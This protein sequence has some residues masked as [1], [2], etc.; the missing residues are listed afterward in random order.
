MLGIGR[1]ATEQDVKK[2]YYQLAKKWHPDTNKVRRRHRRRLPDC[3][4]TATA[5]VAFPIVMPV[6]PPPPVT[7]QLMSCVGQHWNC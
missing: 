3:Y 2:S 4:A 5:T 7:L 6:L 1:S